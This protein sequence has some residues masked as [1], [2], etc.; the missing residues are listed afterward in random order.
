MSSEPQWKAWLLAIRPRT[1]P[2][3]AAP[4][5][6]GT[7][8]AFSAGQ[9]RL[10][11]ALAAALGAL[12]LQVASNLANDL[13]DFESGA[14]AEDRIGPARASQLGLLDSTQMW[15]G[16]AVVLGLT[17]A[18]GFYLLAVAG[19]PV[20]AVGILSILAALAYTGG[21]WPFGYKGLGDP[22]VFFF[23]G[24]VA[25]T[26]T[27]YVQALA[28]S[29]SAFLAS[30]P[31]GALATAILVVN[32]VRDIESDTRANKNTLAVRFGRRFGVLEYAA[33]M[34]LA[35]GLLPVFWLALDRSPFVLL[36][37]LSLP[38]ALRLCQT[39]SREVEGPPLNAALAATA[40]LSL[41]F[42][43]L[44]AVGWLL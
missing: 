11:P 4:V 42:S 20:V 16:M 19:W 3:A 43:I 32:N 6:V 9:A 1:L 36:P 5:V 41:L 29:T 35:Y 10:G 12:G 14:D 39:L 7:A 31:V 26:G 38:R 2:V 22:A 23:F 13:F 34:A 8:V 25:V 18:V 27:Y 21:P 17:V 30:L 24:I 44:L 40:Q 15:R 33:L 37:L 28:W